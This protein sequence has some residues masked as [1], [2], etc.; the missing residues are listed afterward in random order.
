ML[1]LAGGGERG[2]KGDCMLLESLMSLA[3][4][5]RKALTQSQPPWQTPEPK[6]LFH[7][8]Q[9]GLGFLWPWDGS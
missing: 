1:A 5:A 7:S 2:Q 6:L 3:T 8:L 4:W 9:G